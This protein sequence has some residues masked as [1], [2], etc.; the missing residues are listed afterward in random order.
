MRTIAGLFGRLLRRSGGINGS[1]LR[2]LRC[3]GIRQKLL[4]GADLLKLLIVLSARIVDAPLK[5]VMQFFSSPTLFR[6]NV[7]AF[8]SGDQIVEDGIRS[9]GT[10]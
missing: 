6:G 3:E 2:P 8:R 10:T 4:L 9:R 1:V 7:C 5:C